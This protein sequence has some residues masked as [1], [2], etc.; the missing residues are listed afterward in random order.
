MQNIPQP[1][2]NQQAN[3]R[4]NEQAI[5]NYYKENRKTKICK[6][7]TFEATL[8]EAKMKD[9]RKFK[10]S[11]CCVK[12]L[13]LLIYSIFVLIFT[14]AGFYFRI[15][16]NEG[17]EAYKGLLERN[18]SL[19][20][21]RFPN[22]Y[23]TAK[24]VSYL[25]EI[26]EVDD[27]D[28]TYIRYKY[29]MCPF[30]DYKEFCTIERYS[31]RK[32]NYMDFQVKR[33][34]YFT[35]NENNYKSGQCSQAQYYI[36][37]EERGEVSYQPK[38]TPASYFGNKIKINLRSLTVL[39][40]WCKFGDYDNSIYLSFI[41]LLGI[42]IILLIYDLIINKKTLTSG[43]KYYVAIC[44][45]MIYWVIFRIYTILFL[46]LMYYGMF[47][48][49]AYPN[50]VYDGDDEDLIIPDP[51]F[52][53]SVII[54]FEEEKLWKD[55]RLNALIFC[56]ICFVLFIMVMILGFYKKLIYNYLAFN[57]DERKEEEII[58]E[59][60]P[61]IRRSAWIRVVNKSYNFEINQNKYIYVKENRTEK[62]HTFKEV[63][64][65]NEVYYL[66]LRFQLFPI[67]LHFL[68]LK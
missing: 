63:I 52:D 5:L 59:N 2:E 35:C 37:L 43:V 29:G 51:F 3:E 53:N 68:L 10:S 34:N 14:C 33:G 4:E 9:Y 1:Q 64:F 39:K 15:S 27:Y 65:Q 66:H 57:F 18:M 55:K 19:I 58:A 25:T 50:T 48:S 8:D 36:Y 17:Y 30:E 7:I 62:I 41:I 67:V 24:L 6:E 13:S 26:N 54:L 49:L 42:F 32:C 38:I 28:C 46:I 20:D 31:E 60:I 22:E 16:N 45:Y 21:T 47:V 40:L 23:E 56:G 11:C 44:L 12:P 61:A